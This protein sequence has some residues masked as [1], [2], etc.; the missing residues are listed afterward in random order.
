M[1]NSAL[2]TQARTGQPHS[3]GLAVAADT[4]HRRRIVTFSNEGACSHPALIRSIC[5]ML[6]VKSCLT[7]EQDEVVKKLDPG[8]KRSWMKV[9]NHTFLELSKIEEKLSRDVAKR[10]VALTSVLK[11][12]KTS[13]SS[14]TR[15]SSHCSWVDKLLAKPLMP[16]AATASKK[17]TAKKDDLAICDVTNVGSAGWL[18]L[19][20]LANFFRGDTLAEHLHKSLRKKVKVP[21]SLITLLNKFFFQNEKPKFTKLKT[22]G[23]GSK[24]SINEFLKGATDYINICKRHRHNKLTREY[25]MSK[26]YDELRSRFLIL[27]TASASPKL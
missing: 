5:R 21:R 15:R 27:K 8:Q 9:L 7:K 13:F 23:L 25:A 26:L 14:L 22:T 2:V 24:K 20:H 17:I 11:R 3:F 6:K 19:D 4:Y 1:Y 16:E 12:F 10:S 18:F